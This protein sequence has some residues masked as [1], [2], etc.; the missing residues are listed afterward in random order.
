M[1]KPITQ[2]AGTKYESAPPNQEVTVDAG[3]NQVAK[4]LRMQPVAVAKKIQTLPNFQYSSNSDLIKGAGAA[5]AGANAS[6]SEGDDSTISVTTGDPSS[7]LGE[8]TIA[9]PTGVADVYSRSAQL[10]RNYMKESRIN[11]RQQGLKGKERR[12][13]MR[14]QRENKRS[15]MAE[16]RRTQ[17]GG[18]NAN[19]WNIN[20]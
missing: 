8:A 10:G 17:L 7:N 11:A 9:A 2:R 12:A 18:E 3:G 6:A 15:K 16:Y 4:F 5:A 20:E 1:A 19:F 13:Y 14:Q